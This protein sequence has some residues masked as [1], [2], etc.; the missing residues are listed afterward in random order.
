MD[1]LTEYSLALPQ[2]G[3]FIAFSIAAKLKPLTAAVSSNIR[4]APLIQ[5]KRPPMLCNLSIVLL[6]SP[7]SNAFVQAQPV[8]ATISCAAPVTGQYLI[9]SQGL[10][11][12]QPMCSLQLE[13]WLPNGSV[14]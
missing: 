7:L 9:V 6:A 4:G 10:R 5:L 12:Q 3:F 14:S 1:L 13:T 2:A 11:G 8:Q